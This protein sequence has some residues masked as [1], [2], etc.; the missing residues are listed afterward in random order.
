[1]SRPWLGIVGRMGVLA[2]AAYPAPLEASWLQ[3]G[4]GAPTPVDRLLPV[5]IG[6]LFL[7]LGRAL[8]R[9]RPNHPLGIRTPWTLADEAVW[10]A[11]HR[12]AG[13][14]FIAGGLI[15]MAGAFLPAEYRPHAAIAGILVAGFVPV[16]YSYL[17]FHWR[18]RGRGA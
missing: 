8:A 14:T 16:L 1:M 18:K 17:A 5:A 7:V 6:A 3:G 11:T 15:T 13:R 2:L 4:T 12:L 10:R 9:V